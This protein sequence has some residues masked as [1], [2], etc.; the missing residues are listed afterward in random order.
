MRIAQQQ[1][2]SDEIAQLGRSQ[3]L[4]AHSPL[5]RLRPFLD[6]DGLLRLGGRLQHAL[7]PYEEKHP[8]ILAKKNH[9]SLLF[10]RDA[11]TASLHGGPQLTRSLLLRSVWILQAGS[12]VRSVV[13][14]C[15]RCAQF[16]AATTEQQMGQLPV[17]RARPSRPFQNAGVDYAGPILLR[18]AKG[19]G[20]KAFKGYVCLFVCQTSRAIHLEAVSDLTSAAFLAAFKRFTARRG[21]CRQLLS[22]NG[23]N[24]RGAARELRSMFKA[25]SA[26]YHECAASLA[27]DGT[28]W[29]FIPPGAPHF[30]GLWEAGVK[31]VKYHLRRVIGEHRL[32][33]EELTTLLAQV[34]ACLNSRPLHALSNDPSDLVALTPGHL[35]IGESLLTIPEPPHLD[36]YA[37]RIS[38]RWALVSSMR[39]HLWNRW[40]KEYIHHLQQ[41]KRWPRSRMNLK[42]GALVLVK[43]ELQPPAKW[44][45][46]RITALHPGADGLVRVVTVRTAGSVFKR[47]ITKLCPL[48]VESA[49]DPDRDK[50]NSVGVSKY[51]AAGSVTLSS[52]RRRRLQPPLPSLT[53]GGPLVYSIVS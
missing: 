27:N 33:Y 15:V 48:P 41:L 7:L 12:L 35:L 10:A 5:L 39:D 9:L 20:H 21:L 4:Q 22:D 45:L 28:E 30:G 53:A 42:V 44:A 40:S 26:F 31:S 8:L 13:Y 37:G 11:H 50:R 14:R 49:P 23:T 6:A 25:A 51:H 52:H 36:A 2:F 24:F 38:S 19:R 29:R 46:A 34:E 18:A 17:E 32:T 3:P 43:D 47:P 16:R 1:N